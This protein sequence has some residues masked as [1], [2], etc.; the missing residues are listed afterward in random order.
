M[1][2]SDDG[3]AAGQL[4]ADLTALWSLLLPRGFHVTSKCHENVQFFFFFLFTAGA[5]LPCDKLKFEPLIVSLK[6][7]NIKKTI[8]WYI[9]SWALK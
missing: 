7:K 3:I 1:S 6:M 9:I 8:R 4:S 5:R 2:A